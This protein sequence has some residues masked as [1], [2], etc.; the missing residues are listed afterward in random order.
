MSDL[1]SLR[2]VLGTP[3]IAWLIERVRHRAATGEGADGA[4]LSGRVRLASPSADQRLAVA[5]LVGPPKRATDSLVVDLAAVEQSLRRHL[6]PDG[7]VSAVAAL[8]GPIENRRAATL[9][10]AAAWRGTA[11]AFAPAVAVHPELAGWFDDF[12]SHGDLKR[13]ARA[14]AR[15]QLVDQPLTTTATDLAASAATVL[16]HLPSSGELRSVF[17]RRVLGDA[18]SLD[19]SRPLTGMVLAAVR[20]LGGVRM[21][22][23]AIQR[24]VWESVGVFVSGLNSTAI[25]LGVSAV[26]GVA[27]AGGTAAATAVWLDAARHAPIAIVLTLDQVLSDAVSPMAAAGTIFVCEN[28]AII[29]AAAT[30]LREADGPTTTPQACVVCLAGQPTVAVARLIARLALAGATVRY[31]G[32]FDWA[33]LRIASNLSSITPWTP[34][35]FDAEAY[36]LAMQSA[37]NAPSTV[38]L[39]GPPAESPWDPS[40][41]TAMTRCGLAVEEETMIDDL[42]GDVIQQW[43]P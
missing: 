8:T 27:V 28:T 41:A 26:P 35:R 43:A 34:W 24:E 40:L 21:P 4:P 30:A 29:E 20:A 11:A 9:A 1:G 42:V 16:A 23:G 5:K 37:Q 14:E 31:H 17:A 32:D 12:L 18:H 13:A 19:Y 36:E 15:R 38:R 25:C 2:G 10:E 22:E 7:L 6:W 39:K 33:G 3:D